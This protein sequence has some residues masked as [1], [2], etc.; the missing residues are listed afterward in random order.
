M[1]NGKEFALI[2]AGGQGVRMGGEIPK[3][4]MMLDGKPLLMKTIEAFYN[5]S[6]DIRVIVVLHPQYF[7]QWQELC[8]RYDFKIPFNLSEGGSERY[9]S[10]KNGLEKVP[11]FTE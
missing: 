5:Y 10:V 4:F 7:S 8:S 6:K 3:Q 2:V 1:G 9:H 11:F